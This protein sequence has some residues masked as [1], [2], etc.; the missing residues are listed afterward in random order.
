MLTSLVPMHPGADVPAEPL[1]G[2]RYLTAWSFEPLPLFALVASA[3][4]YLYGV[5]RMKAA[6]NPWPLGRTLAFVVGGHGALLLAVASPLATY[7]VT[8]LSVHMAQHMLLAMV[9]PIFLVLG[10]PIT[11]ALRTLPQGGR[12]ALLT[13]LHSRVVGVFTFPVVA[14]AIFVAN[15]FVLYYSGLYE[16]TLRH[17]W[18]HDLNHLHFVVIGSLWFATLI[19]VDPLPNRAGYPLRVISAFVT[20]PFHAWLGVSIM[21]A[22]TLIAADWYTSLER[23]WGASPLN[24]QQTAGGIVWISGDLIGLLVFAALFAQWV[25]ASER[26]ARREDRRLDRLDAVAARRS[27]PFGDPPPGRDDGW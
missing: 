4:L 12:R 15:P 18:L 16:Q 26:E 23:D 3:G 17:A 5:S 14:G 1:S 20:L 9:A 2:W 22:N 21:S 10:A 19:G 25:R 11:L 27:V 13:V 8:L 7:D 6:G 24:D